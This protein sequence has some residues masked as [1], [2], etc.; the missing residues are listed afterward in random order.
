M[1]QI[2][3]PIRYPLSGHSRVTLERAIDR[4]REEEA[5]LT[6]L[7]VNLYQD[8]KRTTRSQLKREV[9]SEFGPL[10]FARYAIREGLLI[11]ESILEE[12]AAE[13]ADIVVI[14]KKQASRWR[15]MIRRLTDDPDI[16]QFLQEKLDCQIVTVMD[17]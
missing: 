5:S 3:V 4:A 11:E 13:H 1:T 15:E 6:I 14:G 9:E 10:P 12:V 7:H 16:E 17:E 2:V 8:G